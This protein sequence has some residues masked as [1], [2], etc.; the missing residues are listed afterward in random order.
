MVTRGWTGQATQRTVATDFAFVEVRVVA[1]LAAAAAGVGAFVATA[2]GVR[3]AVVREEGVSSR[4]GGLFER[5]C[6]TRC[7]D[8]TAHYLQTHWHES[9]WVK[10]TGFGNPLGHFSDQC[11]AHFQNF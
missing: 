9:S 8:T 11:S 5:K 2:F 6:R 3:V 4:P 10:K 1:A 7:P